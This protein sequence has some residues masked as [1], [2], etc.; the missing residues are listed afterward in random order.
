MRSMA[1]LLSLAGSRALVTGAASGIGLATA[2]LLAKS[3][4]TVAINFL[5]D[6]KRGPEAVAKLKADGF[7]AIE[8]PGSVG[9]PGDAERMVTKAIDDL[10]R[11]DLLAA[12][13]GTPYFRSSV[14]MERLDLINEE[15]WQQILGTNLVGAFRCAKTA[16]DALRAARGAIVST[17]SIAAYGGGS[18]IVYSASKAGVVNLTKNLAKAL[19]PEVRVNAIAP[20]AVD[21]AWQIEW[22]E[23]QRKLFGQAAPLKR[24]GTPEDM[25]EVIVFL[26]FAAAYVTGQTVTVDGGL[27]V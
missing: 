14:P 2:T 16:A 1:A 26:G 3:G 17:A 4:A 6:D 7:S 18:S 13:A 24:W 23:E 8:A 20:G 27:T 5:P 19:A 22:T 25:A 11:L 12:N 15:V 21:S 9:E 10:G